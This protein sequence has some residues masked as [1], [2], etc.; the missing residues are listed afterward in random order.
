[1]AYGYGE[2]YMPYMDEYYPYGAPAA[3]AL[4]LGISFS[5]ALGTGYGNGYKQQ[6]PLTVV[7][8]SKAV[9]LR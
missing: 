2:G 1:M 4:G 6:G 7:G 9:F 5:S 3:G 8:H